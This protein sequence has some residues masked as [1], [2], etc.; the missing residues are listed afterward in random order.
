MTGIIVTGHGSYATGIT[1]GLKLLA[2]RPEYYVPV[3]FT[4]EDSMS[5]LMQKLEQAVECLKDCES[6]LILT[7]LAGGS[8]FNAAIRMKMEGGGNLE[9]IGGANLGA[10]LHAY[11]MRM[12]EADGA[13]VARGSLKAGKEAMVLFEASCVVGDADDYEE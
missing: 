11:M 1:S 5:S 2:G 9:V 7:D 4:P 13:E 8:P 10:V 6:I 3:D 12:T